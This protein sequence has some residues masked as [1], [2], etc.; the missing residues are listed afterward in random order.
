[1]RQ[2]ILFLIVNTAFFVELYRYR[3]RGED[4]VSWL[5]VYLITSAISLLMRYLIGK[6][7]YTDNE[8]LTISLTS[9]LLIL[10]WKFK[11]EQ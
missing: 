3:Q 9:L 1:M 8:G 7:F 11:K 10:L 5:K 2:V 6:G 4:W